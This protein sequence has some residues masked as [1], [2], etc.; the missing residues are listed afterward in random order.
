MNVKYLLLSFLF[1]SAFAMSQAKKSKADIL[2]FEYAYNEAIKEYY[3]EMNKAPLTNTQVL[4]LADSFYKIG[5]YKQ[6]SEKYLEV[7]KKDSTMSNYHFS[8]MLAAMTKTSGSDRAKAFLATK[9]TA[10]SPEFLENSEFNFELLQSKEEDGLDFKIFN[11]NANSPQ[12]DFAPSFYGDRLLFSSSRRKDSKRIYA[13]SGEGYLDIYIAK[14]GLGGQILNPNPFTGVPDSKFHTATPHYSK[15]LNAVFFVLSNANKGKLSFDENGKNS[16]ALGVARGNGSFDYLLRDLSTSFYYPFYDSDN[17]KLYFA[18]NFEDSLGGTDIY[19]VYTNNG[20]IMSSPIN[21]G[22]RINTPANEISPYVF[23]NSLYFSSDIFYGLGGMDVYKSEIGEEDFYSIPVNLGDQ[24]NSEKDE[25]G[26]II[27][28][29]IED[30]LIGYF[31]SNRPGG[32]GNDDIY[33]FLMDKKPGFKTLVIRGKITEYNSTLGIS[34][35]GVKLLDKENE[36]IKEVYSQDDGEF[37]IE[38]P[39]QEYAKLEIT[40]DRYSSFTQEYDE[41]GLEALQNNT[42]FSVGLTELDALVQERE[43]QTVIKMNKFF[44]GR[45]RSVVTPE[46]A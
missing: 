8:K 12:A 34:R 15:D 3:N 13:P 31:S 5:N 19:Y 2:F 45:S 44:F 40:K 27:K 11:I 38:T 24:I 1:V 14:V 22:P 16:L 39:W 42:N 4:N 30:G 35:V 43:G 9:T 32:K 18:A 25:F 33:G 46:I 37:M 7:Y 23:E 36:V 20:Q 29:N 41:Q 17:G 21:L 6:A 26:F 10:L 28:N